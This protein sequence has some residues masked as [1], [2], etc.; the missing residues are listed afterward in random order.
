M[1]QINNQHPN[2]QIKNLASRW[3]VGGQGSGMTAAAVASAAVLGIGAFIAGGASSAAWF[4][5]PAKAAAPKRAPLLTPE[6]M[7]EMHEQVRFRG[8]LR[9]TSNKLRQMQYHA[10]QLGTD[11]NGLDVL[12]EQMDELSDSVDP[13]NRRRS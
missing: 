4:K 5:D 3:R 11:I 8:Q 2:F 10:D 12:L 7:V 9:V 13:K 6:E 1:T